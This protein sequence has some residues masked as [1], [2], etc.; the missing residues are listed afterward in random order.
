VFQFR[1]TLARLD[2]ELGR[3]RDLLEGRWS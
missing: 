3:Y 2:D 1:A